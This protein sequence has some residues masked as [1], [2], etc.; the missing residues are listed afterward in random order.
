MRLLRE[1]KSVSMATVDGEGCPQVRIIDVMLVEDGALYFCTA[2]GKSFYEELIRTKKVAILGMTKEYQ[3]IRLN[4]EAE[5]M[6][7]QKYWVDRIFEENPVM[8][9]VYP[10][11]ARYILEPFRVKDG[12]IEYF[13]LNTHPIFREDTGIG[14]FTPLQKGF[15]ITETCILCGSCE[16]V[17]PQ[18][19]IVC[20]DGNYV[21]GQ[22][23]GLH[24]GLCMETC[25]AGA[26]VKRG[27]NYG[28]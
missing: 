9:E 16:A 6:K 14:T 1:L 25:P 21:I 7:E 4:G 11:M 3:T 28:V 13:D 22:E 27:Q 19:A 12:T 15:Q 10:G 8:N 17:C 23:H 20:K 2:R 24:C 18:K 26:I 5:K